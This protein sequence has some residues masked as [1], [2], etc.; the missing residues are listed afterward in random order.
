MDGN[1]VG[2]WSLGKQHTA[3]PRSHWVNGYATH[4]SGDPGQG[5][6]GLMAI[7]LIVVGTQAKV[8]LG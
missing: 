5:L 1:S 8:S 7:L 2:E 3:R 4:C 6:T